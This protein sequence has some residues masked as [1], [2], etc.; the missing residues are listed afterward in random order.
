MFIYDVTKTSRHRSSASEWPVPSRPR[1]S[2]P[3][4]RRPARPLRPRPPARP[5]PRLAVSRSPNASGPAPSPCARSVATKS[6]PSCSSA[7]SP[8]SASCVRSR[9]T[10]SRTSASSPRRSWPCRRRRRPTS[11]VS[12]RTPTCAPSTPSA[13]PSSPRTSSL[14]AASVAS[15]RKRPTR[16]GPPGGPSHRCART[17]KTHDQH[18]GSP[19][20]RRCVVRSHETPSVSCPFGTATALVGKSSQSTIDEEL[21]SIAINRRLVRGLVNYVFASGM[22]MTQLLG[23]RLVYSLSLCNYSDHPLSGSG[24]GCFAV[25][26]RL[27]YFLS[28]AP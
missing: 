23:N 8:S 9:R 2:P 15:A 26:S 5:P 19:L 27:V 10:S 7:S 13:S 1:A 17:P 12:S 28:L 18:F 3:A 14:P 21:L 16:S 22:T 11:S 6:R 25:R 4:A 24:H 20:V